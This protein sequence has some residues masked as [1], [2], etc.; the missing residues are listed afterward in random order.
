[1][2]YMW[3]TRI[4][5]ILVFHTLITSKWQTTHVLLKKLSVEIY[6]LDWYSAVKW[7]SRKALCFLYE[8]SLILVSLNWIN[9]NP[10]MPNFTVFLILCCNFI[11]WV[12]NTQK[13]HISCYIWKK[14]K[15]FEKNSRPIFRSWGTYTYNWDKIKV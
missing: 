11:Y 13:E 3:L 8:V 4:L 12:N 1:M 9:F 10:F 15:N 2:N 5:Q 14:F 6:K 7:S